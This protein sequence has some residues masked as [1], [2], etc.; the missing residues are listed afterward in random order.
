[1]RMSTAPAARVEEKVLSKR[2]LWIA[3]FRRFVVRIHIPEE[4]GGVL[5]T[6]MKEKLGPSMVAPRRDLDGVMVGGKPHLGPILHS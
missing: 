5:D 3:S 6:V 1:M 2:I 4:V